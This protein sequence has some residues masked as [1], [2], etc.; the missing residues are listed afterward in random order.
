MSLRFSVV[1]ACLNRADMIADAIESVRAQAWPDVQHIVVDGG[2]TDATHSVLSRYPDLDVSIGPD[3]GVFDAWN[4]GLARATGD[5]VCILNSDDLLAPG[6][7]ARVA[8]EFAR[9]K[10]VEVVS[11]PALNF[12]VRDDGDWDVVYEHREAPGPTLAVERMAIWGP[13]INARFLRRETMARF[14]PFDLAYPLGSDNDFMLRLAHAAP[15]AAYIDDVVYFYRTHASSL[16]MDPAQRNLWR[17][18]DLTLRVVEA[19]L[20]RDD[21][22]PSERAALREHHALRAVVNS[23]ALARRGKASAAAGLIVRGFRTTP[24]LIPV[25]L[26]RRARRRGWSAS[27]VRRMTPPAY[28]RAA[29]R[30][31]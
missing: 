29:S 10:T 17:G 19:F 6:T 16:S 26:A 21:L 13:A 20:K 23:M 9:D 30:S 28:C 31:S 8:A 15:R 1:T 5:V 24:G 14:L 27:P 4:K 11:G 25:L 7:F 2:S 3:S 22:S 18:T 12:V